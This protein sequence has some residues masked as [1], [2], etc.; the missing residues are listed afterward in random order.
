MRLPMCTRGE[1]E[2]RPPL[3]HS[4]KTNPAVWARPQI[5]HRNYSL[6]S[7]TVALPLT[8]ISLQRPPLSSIPKVAIVEGFNCKLLMSIP[9]ICRANVMLSI[10]RL[11]VLVEQY[12]I[13]VEVCFFSKTTPMK[14]PR[15][16]FLELMTHES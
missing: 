1:K 5:P 2:K 16:A 11:L 14:S 10:E 6:L 7:K 8:A 15:K 12:I 13:T 9:F 3:S 4:I